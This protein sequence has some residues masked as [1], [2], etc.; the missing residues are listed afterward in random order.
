MAD[1]CQQ[2]TSNRRVYVEGQAA[3]TQDDI[4]TITGC[5]FNVGGRP[6]PCTMQKWQV[7]ATHILINGR[8]AIL[9]NSAGQCQSAE[10]VPQGAPNVCQTQGRVKGI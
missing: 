10:Q 5:S 6:Q 1:R 4:P 7:P 9:Q 2:V 3:L 8:Y